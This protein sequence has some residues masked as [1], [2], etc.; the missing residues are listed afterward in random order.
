M[1]GAQA[2]KDFHKKAQDMALEFIKEDQR[3]VSKVLIL[4]ES[5]L[6]RLIKP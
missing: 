4:V 3:Q 2:V 5:I 6:F 1:G